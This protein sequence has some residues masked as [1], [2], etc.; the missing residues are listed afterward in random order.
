MFNSLLLSFFL[1]D[2]CTWFC[3]YWFFLNK[4]NSV[5]YTHLHPNYYHALNQ[6]PYWINYL[7]KRCI[8]LQIINIVS[9]IYYIDR[10]IY[11]YG[12]EKPVIWHHLCR[13]AMMNCSIWKSLSLWIPKEIEWVKRNESI[14]PI[15][16]KKSSSIL[17]E[18]DSAVIFSDDKRIE[19]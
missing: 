18:C 16:L 14:F 17:P 1:N 13:M 9:E 4:I 7:T 2:L 19:F 12:W 11:Q 10:I 15:L 3:I 6:Q 8:S 5:S